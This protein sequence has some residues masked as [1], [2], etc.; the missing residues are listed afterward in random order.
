ML[1]TGGGGLRIHAIQFARTMDAVVVASTRSAAKQEALA[2]AGAQEVVVPP[3]GDLA[4]GV[5]TVR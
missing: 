2:A 5:R 3:D 4:V 1:V